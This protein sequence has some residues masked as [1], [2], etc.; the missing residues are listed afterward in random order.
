[1]SEKI[2]CEICGCEVHVIQTH[3]KKEHQ[4]VSLE[5]YTAK[6]P[7]APLFSETV[8]AEMKNRGIDMSNIGKEKK[9]T[10]KVEKKTSNLL[11]E[12]FENDHPILLGKSGD[13]IKINV[14]KSNE[15]KEL[16]PEV[17][18]GYV[19]NETTL[20]YIMLGIESNLNVYLWGHKGSGKSEMFE[21]ISA[22]TN[23]PMIRIQHTVNTEE[24]HIVGMW[25][26]KDGKTV[27]ELGALALAMKHGWLYLA[28]E[29]DFAMPSV[30]SVYQ[31]VLDGKPLIIKEAD[32]ENRIIKPHENFRF[33]ATGNTNGSGDETGLYQGTTIQNS[34]NYDRFGVVIYQDYMPEEKEVEI[35]V[36]KTKLAKSQAKNLAKFAKMVRDSYA[37]GKVSDTISTR[38][39]VNSALLGKR[40]NCIRT[41]IDLSFANKLSSLDKEVITGIATRIFGDYSPQTQMIQVNHE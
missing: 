31:A 7:D 23:R 41:G 39:L 15:F 35:I 5:E 8:I 17:N 1:M 16:V 27:F 34:A 9:T 29:Y 18:S 20:K 6:Y 40:L 30:L 32:E 21:Q 12:V 3:L 11:H 36:K 28:D 4:D 25:T 22:R 37:S 33:V 38:A 19:F 10:E 2:K 24:S 13:G 26:V 14:L